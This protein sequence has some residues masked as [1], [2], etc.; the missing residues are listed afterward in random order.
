MVVT[1]LFLEYL[2]PGSAE[3]VGLAV[4]FLLGFRVYLGFEVGRHL[5]GLFVGFHFRCAAGADFRLKVG[6]LCRLFLLGR[7]VVVFRCHRVTIRLVGVVCVEEVVDNFGEIVDIT[8]RLVTR[9]VEAS[10]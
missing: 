4:G 7:G 10:S 8:L 6:D 9:V 3:R 2:N 5:L 1:V